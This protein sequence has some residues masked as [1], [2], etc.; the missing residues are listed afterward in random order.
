LVVAAG[1]VRPLRDG[2][3]VVPAISESPPPAED[4]PELARWIAPEFLEVRFD[5]RFFAA[6]CG[7]DVEARPDGREID[8]AWWARP[9]DILAQH[10]LGETLMWPTYNTLIA[11]AGCSSV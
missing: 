7:T 9:A 4:V 5:A 2:E 11:L 6:A 8:L 1:G 3:G 10:S